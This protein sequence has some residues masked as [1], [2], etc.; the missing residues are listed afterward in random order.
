MTITA[1]KV[2][3]DGVQPSSVGSAVPFRPQD[4]AS[5]DEIIEE[6]R[7]GRMFILVDDEGRENEGDLVIA[8][9]A[10]TP[11]AINFM[12]RYARG[13]IC[14]TLTQQR[15]DEL[16]LKLQPKRGRSEFET[17]F[18]VS[19]E[20]REG[21]TTGISAFDR[22]TTV[23][24]AVNP[25]SKAV[26]LV[27]PG[28]IFP[29]IARPGGVLARE[30]HT[31]ASVDL[32]KRAGRVPAAVICEVL[33]DDGTMARLPQL[34]AFARQHHLKVGAIKDLVAREQALV[35]STQE[36]VYRT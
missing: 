32:M 2:M 31:E 21:V 15:A 30:G 3:R 18:T 11:N 12:A 24:T 36:S 6:A 22:A 33:N 1:R 25:A 23:L 14:L 10:V 13:L 20:A 28:H 4:L 27:T 34:L 19:I 29:L 17:A 9:D 16:E 35:D 8:A 26:D 5:V 7:Q